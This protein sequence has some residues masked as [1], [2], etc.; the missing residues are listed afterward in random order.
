MFTQWLNA[1]VTPLV[2][3]MGTARART[4]TKVWKKVLPDNLNGDILALGE[5][6][7]WHPLEYNHLNN[8][9]YGTV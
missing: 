7:K 2:Q 6:G 4:T 5:E 1:A 9:I 3:M 8:K